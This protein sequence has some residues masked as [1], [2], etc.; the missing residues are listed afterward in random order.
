LRAKSGYPVSSELK[1][2]DGNESDALDKS[3]ANLKFKEVIL[4]DY[5]DKK[6]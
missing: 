4:G 2:Y 5:P 6:K 1:I 3:V